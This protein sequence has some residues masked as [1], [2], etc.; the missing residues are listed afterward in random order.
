ML[1]I[2][3]HI[4]LYL[5]TK[6]NNTFSIITRCRLDGILVQIFASIFLLDF[7]LLLPILR[8]KGCDRIYRHRGLSAL[9]PDRFSRNAEIRQLLS[10]GFDQDH[11]KTIEIV[12]SLERKLFC[13]DLERKPIDALSA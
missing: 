11:P 9:F 10:L 5:A 6:L 1:S 7:R 13:F 3:F 12:T 2:L 4:Q 8:T